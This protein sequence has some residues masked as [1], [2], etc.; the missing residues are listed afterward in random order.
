MFN[1]SFDVLLSDLTSTYFEIDAAQLPEGDKRH[2]R[3][4]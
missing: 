3:L 4:P 1:A 2:G